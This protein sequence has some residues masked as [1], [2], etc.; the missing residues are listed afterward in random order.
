[1]LPG[2]S[3][4][5][6][7]SDWTALPWKSA[8]PMKKD[9]ILAPARRGEVLV[10][11]DCVISGYWRDEAATAR[12]LRDVWLFTGAAGHFDERNMLQS[13]GC[14][15]NLIISGGTNIYPREIE[16]VLLRHECAVIGVPDPGWA[17]NVLA[18]VVAGATAMVEA[19]QF[20]G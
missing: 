10:R 11:S 6:H 3:L 12:A 19:E 14:S 4:R 5:V 8:S 18:L 9:G 1:M 13:M 7:G 16:E 15:K 17:E 2:S 20:R